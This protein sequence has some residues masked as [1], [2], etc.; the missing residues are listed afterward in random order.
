MDDRN[1]P[2]WRLTQRGLFKRGGALGAALTV[3]GLGGAIM[4]ASAA[5][6]VRVPD[7]LPDPTRPAGTAPGAMP[8]D[9]VVCVMMENH[10]SFEG[11][12]PHRGERASQ[13]GLNPGSTSSSAAPRPSGEAPT[14]TLPRCASAIARTMARPS[15]APPP[16]RVRP[17]SV[18]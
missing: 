1:H 10:P 2:S 8:F 14:R 4:S 6:A 9:H 16:A 12:S 13:L 17:V 15:P 7:S 5:A 18:R 3:P 11:R